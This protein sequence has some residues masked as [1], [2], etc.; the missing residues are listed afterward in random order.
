MKNFIPQAKA[1]AASYA[2]GFR[3]GFRGIT[4]RQMA[5]PSPLN[6]FLFRSGKLTGAGL[7]KIAKGGSV[8]SKV[9][10]QGYSWARTGAK[11]F[12]AKVRGFMLS[13]VKTTKG[14]VISLAKKISGAAQK[15]ASA[16]AAGVRRA[17][18][19]AKSALAT[20]GKKT[21]SFV[22]K[23]VKRGIE[24]AWSANEKLADAITPKHVAGGP[25]RK[26]R[27][28][29]WEKRRPD[30]IRSRT[31][32]LITAEALLAAYGIGKAVEG[33]LD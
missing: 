9:L 1:A 18:G 25:F 29:S 13:A 16:A 4:P 28:A 12:I 24:K 8:V 26:S 23:A 33:V 31:T 3:Q 15:G 32:K 19:A 10:Y 21:K 17:A 5:S 11:S 14:F 2:A 27:Q 6:N 22:G 20:A 7:A 30:V